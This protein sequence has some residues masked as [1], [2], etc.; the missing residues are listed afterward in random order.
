MP[1][2]AAASTQYA[3][4]SASISLLLAGVDSILV[5]VIRDELTTTSF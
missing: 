4:H 2:T 3:A 1:N 5:L